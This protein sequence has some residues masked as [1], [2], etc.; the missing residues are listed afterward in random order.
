MDKG[1]IVKIRP[2]W[3]ELGEAECRFE[4]LEDNGNRLVL[5]LVCDP[6]EFPIRP[7]SLRFVPQSVVKRLFSLKIYGNTFG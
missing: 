5:A 1:T 7:Q 4:V 2:E 6:M 3:A